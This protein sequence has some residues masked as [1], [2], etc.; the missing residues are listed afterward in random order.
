M[1]TAGLLAPSF[2]V[3]L[4]ALGLCTGSASAA[5]AASASA[6]PAAPA[7]APVPGHIVVAPGSAVPG[8]LVYLG[9]ACALP[10]P[11]APEPVLRTVTSPAFADLGRLSRLGSMAF[12]GDATLLPHLASGTYPVE[13]ICSNGTVSTQFEVTATIPPTP[14]PAPAVPTA[15]PHGSGGPAAGTQGG[16]PRQPGTDGGVFVAQ[17][18]SDPAP[19]W[20]WIIGGLLLVAVGT[21]AAAFAI[22]HHRRASWTDAP[23]TSAPDP[24]AARAEKT[25]MPPSRR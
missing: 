4:L 8:Q 16:E 9:G 5:S 2:A 14:T 11:G 15:T 12:V 7:T 1:R 21:G 23:D 10:V 20:P 18:R 25:L 13:A 6:D 3:A 24:W 17:D 22:E 19:A